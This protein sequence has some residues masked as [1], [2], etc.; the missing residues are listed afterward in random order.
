MVTYLL[1]AMDDN[2]DSDRVFKALADP[3]RRLILDRLIDK[4]GQ[5]LGELEAAVTQS[6]PMTRFGVMKHVRV[7]VEAELVTTRRSG[8]TTLHQLNP[9][10]IRLIHDRWITKFTQ[11]RVAALADLKHDLEASS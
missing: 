10:P 8:R 6:S 3:T 11:A 7:L 1:S 2:A 5:T 4:D 9:V